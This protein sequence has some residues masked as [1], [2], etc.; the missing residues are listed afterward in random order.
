MGDQGADDA[1]L[2]I[3]HAD[4]DPE[5]QQ[6]AL[7]L[8]KA[9]VE[10]DDALARHLAYLTDRVLVAHGRPQLYGT[11]YTEEDNRLQPQPV[12]DPEQLDARRAAMGLDSAAAYDHR[13]QKTY[14]S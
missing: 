6:Q 7:E 14:L 2:L 8:L 10:A 9:A 11:Q 12:R 13:M 5:F 4:R 3:Q 1:W